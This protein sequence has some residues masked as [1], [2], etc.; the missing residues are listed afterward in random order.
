MGLYKVK[1]DFKPFIKANQSK[2][3]ILFFDV[4]E[5]LEP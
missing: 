4:L 3:V 2:V 5:A 1:D